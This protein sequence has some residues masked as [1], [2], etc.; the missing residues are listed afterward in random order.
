MGRNKKE[1]EIIVNFPIKPEEINQLGTNFL[2]EYIL[3]MQEYLV[4]MAVDTN[5]QQG[6]IQRVLRQLIH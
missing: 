4:T 1:Y 2:K 6:I 5:R 3:F